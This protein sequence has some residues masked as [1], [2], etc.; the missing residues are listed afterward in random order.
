MSAETES[1]DRQ[2][3][4]DLVAKLNEL[5]DELERANTRIEKLEGELG[6]GGGERWR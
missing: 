6:V 3:V 1:I 4:T 2:T 5:E